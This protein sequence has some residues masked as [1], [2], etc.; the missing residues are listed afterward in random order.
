MLAQ[1][2][3]EAPARGSQEAFL[4]YQSEGNGKRW[5]SRKSSMGQVCRAVGPR[6]TGKAMA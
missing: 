3:M 6:S 1:A 4:S 2:R 5:R